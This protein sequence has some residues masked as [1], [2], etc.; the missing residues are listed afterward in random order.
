MKSSELW[1]VAKGVFKGIS[2]G[3]KTVKTSETPADVHGAASIAFSFLFNEEF[4]QWSEAA[5][6]ERVDPDLRKALQD[7]NEKPTPKNAKKVEKVVQ[8]ILDSLAPEHFEYS[9]FKVENLGRMSDKR[10][11]ELLDGVDYLRALFKKRGMEKLLD[12]GAKTIILNIDDDSE[13]HGRYHGTTKLIELMPRA[14]GTESSRLWKNWVQEVFLHEFGHYIHLN[15]LS[16]DAKAEWDRGWEP[17][18]NLEKQREETLSITV[19]DRNRFLKLIEKSNWNPSAAVKNLK[20]IDKLKMAYWLREAAM[21]PLIGPKNFK[22]TEIGKRYF[23]VLADPQGYLEKERGEPQE[24]SYVQRRIE[25]IRYNLYLDG[26]GNLHIPEDLAKKYVKN[27]PTLG[28]KALEKALEALAIPSDYGKTNERE[29]FAE[30]WVAFMVNPG[31]L[32]ET[33]KTRML[34]TLALSGLYGKQVL[35]L[36]HLVAA[37]Y[38]DRYSHGT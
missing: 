24:E 34:R 33:A 38:S 5:L 8:G 26:Q 21:G 31:A 15:Y 30:T 3:M 19:S 32:S 7:V 6:G 36:A 20:G 13:A 28:D 9:G 2:L 4:K 22:L 10:V 1:Q 23:G 37:Q 18:K 29:D 11:R 12:R 25:K 16:P 17:I 27:D 14:L 35:R